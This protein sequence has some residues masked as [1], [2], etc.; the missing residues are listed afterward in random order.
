MDSTPLLPTAAE[1]P[2]LTVEQAGVLLGI[3]RCSAYAAAKSG[4]IPTLRVGR[5]LLVPTATFRRMLG[6]D[7]GSAS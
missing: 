5:R 4:E 2:T 3:S 6:L 7:D 1:S